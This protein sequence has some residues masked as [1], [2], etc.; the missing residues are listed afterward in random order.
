MPQF[1]FLIGPDAQRLQIVFL[2]TDLAWT[3]DTHKLYVG[4]GVTLGGISAGGMGD[5][6]PEGP[7]GPQ[8]E[9]GPAGPAGPQG[10]PGAVGAQG[11][12][13]PT[14]PQ[15]PPGVDA[16]A[17]LTHAAS[18]RQFQQVITSIDVDIDGNEVIH[19]GWEEIL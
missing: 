12:Q 13:G 8:G 19:T 15:G 11:G 14:G 17:I 2:S 3:T 6:G 9:A 18:G 4:D 10:L 5:G 1:R 16:S 7:P